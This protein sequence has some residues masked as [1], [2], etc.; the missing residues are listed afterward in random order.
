MTIL[1]EATTGEF[2]IF[3]GL[4]SLFFQLEK[5]NM[6]AMKE[7]GKMENCTDMEK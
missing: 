7:I 1:V 3:P 5:G 2:N 6:S 4:G